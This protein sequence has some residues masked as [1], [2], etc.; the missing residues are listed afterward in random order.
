MPET[1]RFFVPIADLEY[2][3]RELSEDI[4]TDWLATVF[5]G[6]EAVPRGPG[7]LEVTLDKS[8][9]EVMVRG[10]ATAGVTMPCARTLDPVPVDL[11]AEVFLLLE[12]KTAGPLPRPAKSKKKQVAS[13]PTPGPSKRREK[14]PERELAEADAA[15]DTYDGE[16]VVLDQFLKEFLLL[17]LPM[18]VLRE[19]LRSEA[20]PAIS[21][22]PEP[23]Q[24]RPRT[25]ALDPRLA[26]LADIAKRLRE[27]KE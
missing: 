1:P 9:R 27:K 10:H 25:E 16:R 24:S 20:T 7:R 26:P 15:K 2:G 22:P 5:E 19:D 14:E 3:E 11:S 12:P 4:P 6:T 23:G 13:G 18:F 17:E 21:A 8:G